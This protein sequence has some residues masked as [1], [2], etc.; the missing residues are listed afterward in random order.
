MQVNLGTM[1]ANRR[2]PVG[3]VLAKAARPITLRLRCARVL[4]AARDLLEWEMATEL[5]NNYAGALSLAEDVG[6]DYDALEVAYE[7]TQWRLETREEWADVTGRQA[8][9]VAEAMAKAWEAEQ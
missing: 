3:E 9:R 4:M 5:A 7:M 1:M 8:G 6:E 2:H